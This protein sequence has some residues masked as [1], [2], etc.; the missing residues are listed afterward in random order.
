MRRWKPDES[1]SVPGALYEITK[2]DLTALDRYEGHP[3]LYRREVVAV[4][5]NDGRSMRALI[6]LMNGPTVEAPPSAGYL[7]GI[8]EGY[9]DWNIPT[10][11]LDDFSDELGNWREAA[12]GR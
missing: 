12:D 8:V 6:Y 3:R 4:D 9:L 11:G 2:A 5:A 10:D 1:S 7:A